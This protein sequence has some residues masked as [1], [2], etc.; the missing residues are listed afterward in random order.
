MPP[1]C[2]FAGLVSTIHGGPCQIPSEPCNI[3]FTSRLVIVRVFSFIFLSWKSL[4]HEEVALYEG[5]QDVSVGAEEAMSSRTHGWRGDMLGGP[6]GSVCTQ[7]EG[8]Q[9]SWP[10]HRE[11]MC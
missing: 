6:E 5:G 11:R 9:A 10:S 4:W 7:E 3:A 1:D 8:G 2:W